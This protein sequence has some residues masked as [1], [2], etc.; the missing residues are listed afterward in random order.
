MVDITQIQPTRKYNYSV[1]LKCVMIYDIYN[2]AQND[3]NDSF[4]YS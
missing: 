2:P 3:R 4:I 1:I